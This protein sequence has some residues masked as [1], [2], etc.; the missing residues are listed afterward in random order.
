MTNSTQLGAMVRAQREQRGLTQAELA[1]RARVT[2]ESVSR[3]E[4]GRDNA[5]LSLVLNVLSALDLD[6]TLEQTGRLDK[7]SED[8]LRAVLGGNW[9]V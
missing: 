5:R 7:T 1:E 3:L 8:T 6:V 2:R 9:V 4:S